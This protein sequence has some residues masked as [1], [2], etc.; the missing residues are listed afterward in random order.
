M[1]TIM[2]TVAAAA[3]LTAAV[4]V[5][6]P[7]A[8]DP[9][10]ADPAIK[11]WISGRPVWKQY[12]G[13]PAPDPALDPSGSCRDN[14]YGTCLPTGDG[15]SLFGPLGAGLFGNTAGPV[16]RSLIPSQ[17]YDGPSGPAGGTAVQR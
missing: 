16:I 4:A 6:G 1:R 3:F 14:G 17:R 8:A 2:A 15:F 10:D 7:A 5:S 13:Y 11:S 9:A 12:S